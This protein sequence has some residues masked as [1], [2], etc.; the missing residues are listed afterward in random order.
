M[1]DRM[2]ELN[3]AFEPVYGIT[4]AM[5]VGIDTGDVV[6]STLGER[7]GP[8]P[9]ANEFVAVGET[10]NRAARL[11]AAAPVG[12]VLISTDTHQHVR[13][14]FGFRPVT[15]LQLK[16][17]AGTV[18]AFEVLS[19][20]P[21]EF[22]LD[23]ARGVE[24]VE[25]TTVGREIELRR[26]QERLWDVV[27][28]QRW[29]V[30]TVL[31]EAGVGKSRLLLEFDRWLAEMPER[32]WW[33]RG[34][35][36]RMTQN[37]AGAML[38]DLISARFAIQAS[39]TAADVAAKCA[40]G[41]AVG[42]GDDPAERRRARLA[43]AWLGFELG[44]DVSAEVERIDPRA[45]REQALATLG[46]YFSGLG[47]QAPVV[48]LLEDVHWADDLSLESLD[49]ADG[50]FRDAPILVVATARV[51]LLE[52]RP[53]W[54]E[55]LA[56]HSRL[57]LEPLSRRSSRAL[58]DQL[59]ARTDDVPQALVDLVITAAEGNPYY[60]EELV[61][62]L[63]ARGVLVRGPERWTVATDQ[64]DRLGALP[65]TLRGV[66]QAR[67]DA[68]SA[69][70]RAVLQRASVIGRVF[71]DDAVVRL[72][73]DPLDQVEL[74]LTDLRVREL[75]DEREHSTFVGTRERLFRHALLRDV[76]YDGVLRVHRRV[77]HRTAA[78]WLREAA[79]DRVD[80]QAANIAEHLDL[81]GEA[82]TAAA[83]YLRAAARATRMYASAE[84]V[85]LLDRGLELVDDDD[86]FRFDLLIERQ[87]VHDWTGAR[88]LQRA[89]LDAL[90]GLGEQLHDPPRRVT[91][92]LA[93]AQWAFVHSEWGDQER[94]ARTAAEVA[95]QAGLEH[96]RAD[97]L[98]MLGK[99]LTWQADHAG[100]RAV[101]D[102]ALA[103]AR[104]SGHPPS[105]PRRCATSPSSTAT[106]TSGTKR[107]STSARRKRCSP[108]STTSRAWRRC[109]SRRRPCGSTSGD[110]PRRATRPRR[111]WRCSGPPG[112]ST[113]RWR[114]SGTWR[115]SPCARATWARPAGGPRSRWTPAATSRTPRRR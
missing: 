72:G 61:T 63:V 104:A 38:R 107:S 58:L 89:D 7:S 6:V 19:E 33:F 95:E 87:A 114:R 15:G 35:A 113:G 115:R 21:H 112:T 110:W 43:A 45:H 60:L 31:G 11:Q 90:D 98:L 28:E 97:A 34:R 88:P 18:D 59:L 46:A 41:F 50:A 53:R 108:R 111:A 91:L 14:A 83:W 105:R 10:V 64:V 99:A 103:A 74:R 9:A 23:A 25:T 13:G 51:E 49:V 5:R 76:V 29:H 94:E 82:A 70:E 1:N 30:V 93:R 8:N 73:D 100:A 24:G 26:L 96:R 79:A 39:D 48:L 85:R 101:I 67:V 68:L 71:W 16:G 92:L 32:V 40:A 37:T 69:T 86:V 55:G 75:I 78:E 77:H 109:S 56:H 4:L 47:A 2:A 66:L 80:E 106:P 52:R 81:A 102:R 44:E 57:L 20:R 12:G 42:L 22:H 84:A 17:I 3:A 62:W 54:G 36:T 65:P 27:D